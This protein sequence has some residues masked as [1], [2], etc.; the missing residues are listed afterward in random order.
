V[1]PLRGSFGAIR[2]WPTRKSGRSTWKEGMPLGLCYVE[3]RK[4][5]KTLDALIRNIYFYKK[6]IFI[7]NLV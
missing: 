7:L 4:T 6:S 5:K 3:T 1:P 2:S